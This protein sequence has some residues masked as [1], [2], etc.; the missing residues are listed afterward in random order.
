M[1][2]E[3]IK[4]FC[5]SRYPSGSARTLSGTTASRRTDWYLYVNLHVDRSVHVLLHIKT[6]GVSIIKLLV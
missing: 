6:V 4:Y 1:G 3:K 2:P 5:K